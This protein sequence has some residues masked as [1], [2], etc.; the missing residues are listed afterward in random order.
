MRR[1]SSR[2]SDNLVVLNLISS[3]TAVEGNT[4]VHLNGLRFF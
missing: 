2:S 3:A 1:A 4:H